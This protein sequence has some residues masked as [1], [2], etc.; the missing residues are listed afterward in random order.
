[1]IGLEPFTQSFQEMG[2][3]EWYLDYESTADIEGLFITIA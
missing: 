2:P 1:M 3:A